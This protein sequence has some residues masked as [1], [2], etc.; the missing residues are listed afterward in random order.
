MYNRS[1]V[2]ADAADV[3]VIAT[4]LYMLILQGSVDRETQLELLTT[5]EKLAD[6]LIEVGVISPN[7]VEYA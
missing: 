3:G 6:Q 7:E 4:V 5:I 2:P 1:V